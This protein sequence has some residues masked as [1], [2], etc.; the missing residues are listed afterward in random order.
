MEGLVLFVVF[1]SPALCTQLLSAASLLITAGSDEKAIFS[2]LMSEKPSRQHSPTPY[3]TSICAALRVCVVN[4]H[5][6]TL[7]TDH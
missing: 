4:V 1:P 3:H 5:A 6:R 2:V 7:K